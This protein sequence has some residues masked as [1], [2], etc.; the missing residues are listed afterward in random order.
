MDA[1]ERKMQEDLRRYHYGDKRSQP[2][3]VRKQA[4]QLLGE[5][6]DTLGKG[7]C[8]G[9][10]ALDKNDLPIEPDSPWAVKWCLTG[11]LEEA[12]RRHDARSIYEA[13]EMAIDAVETVTFGMVVS[14]NDAPERN[15]KEVISAVVKAKAKIAEGEEL[16]RDFVLLYDDNEMHL[17]HTAEMLVHMRKTGWTTSEGGKRLHDNGNYELFNRSAPQA[18]RDITEE[19]LA[20]GVDVDANCY[21]DYWEVRPLWLREF[22]AAGLPQ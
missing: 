13:S 1:K 2:M 8:Q 11:A 6:A 22:L 19:E 18:D 14:F 9:A 21:E 20:R 3:D 15:V 17:Y 10:L 12:R 7:W 5:V 16:M 4:V